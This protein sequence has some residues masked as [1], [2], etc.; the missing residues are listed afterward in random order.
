MPEQEFE[1]LK[2]HEHEKLQKLKNPNYNVSPTR[3]LMKHLDKELSEE[4]IKDVCYQFLAKNGHKN[5]SLTYCKLML[6]S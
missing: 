1:L 6:D 3:M 5:N 2:A 4:Q